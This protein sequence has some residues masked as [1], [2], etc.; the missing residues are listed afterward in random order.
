MKSI[1]T[2]PKIKRPREKLIKYGPNKLSNS[3][4][5][6]IILSTGTKSKNA[7][8]LA[9]HILKQVGSKNLPN[10]SVADLQ[11]IK[12]LGTAKTT[13]IVSGFELSKRLLKGKKS[14]LA[15][16]PKQVYRELKDI[17]SLKKEHFVVFYLNAQNQE[18]TREIV[19]IGTVDLS[20]VHPREVFEGA[21]KNLATQIIVAHN[22]PST[23]PDPSS[24]DIK[25]TNQ[26]VQAGEVVGI[27]VLDHVIVTKNGYYSFKLNNLI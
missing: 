27:T 17:K 13:K 20:V 23:A 8:Q 18:I 16:T 26:L 5:L 9:N 3:E 10:A 4:L 21:I 24:E 2:L 14:T 12:G 25:V 15:L 6:A 19:S 1:K 11:K 7:I 22:H